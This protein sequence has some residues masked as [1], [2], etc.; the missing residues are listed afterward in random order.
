MAHPYKPEHPAGRGRGLGWRGEERK[1]KVELSDAGYFRRNHWVPM[2]KS[3]ELADVNAQM[4]AACREDERRRIAGR[5]QPVGAAMIA[6]REHLL[7]LAEHGF[8]LAEISFPRVDGL[9]CVPVRTNL[10][11][12]PVEVGKQSKCGFYPKC[13]EVRD[14]GRWG[15][16]HERCYEPNQQVFEREYYLDV[17]E[18]KPGA[19]TGGACG[20]APKTRARP[21]CRKQLIRQIFCQFTR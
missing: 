14:E 19:L 8:K 11:S 2:P 20:E 12:V 18:R 17:L 6:E 5:S 15:G 4:L 21:D 10:Y 3:R 7:P 1:G 16:R 9:G 13:V